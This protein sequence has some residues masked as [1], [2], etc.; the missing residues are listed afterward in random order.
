MA[1]KNIEL[2]KKYWDS[3]YQH[4]H[5]HTPSQFCVCVLTEINP[6]ATIIEFGSGN[7]RD[8]HY[9]ASQGHITI[10]M[11]L[12]FEAIKCCKDV[13]NSRNINHLTFFQN[14]I[15]NRESIEEIVNYAREESICKE[16]V[17]YSRFVM[18]SLDDKQ[19][20][21]FLRVL[22]DYMRPD[23]LIYFEFRS[24]ED[25][26]LNKYYGGHFR[27]FIET[28]KFVRF[29]SEKLG[30][31]IDYTITGRGMAKF[32]EEDPFVSRVIARKK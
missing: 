25:S 16:I 8:S 2:N 24:K 23:E 19:E 15:T 17:F 4:N 26:K 6:D 21:D 18:H 27:R 3:F 32:K 22:S 1:N 10:A 13:A 31:I 11:D 5:K 28:D 9:F 7:G 12:S 14:D 20:Q 30:F 29:L